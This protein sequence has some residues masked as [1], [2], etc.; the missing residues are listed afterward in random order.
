MYKDLCNNTAVKI[1]IYL[2]V[3]TD[4]QRD[5]GH[6]IDLTQPEK[7][8]SVII[9]LIFAYYESRM[10]SSRI[11]SGMAGGLKKRLYSLGGALPYGFARTQENKIQKKS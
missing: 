7:E 3:F 2:R 5:F 11:K 4:E 10:A 9:R 1:V 6:S 8:L